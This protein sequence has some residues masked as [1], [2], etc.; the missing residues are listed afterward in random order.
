MALDAAAVDWLLEFLADE[1]AEVAGRAQDL[2]RSLPEG[3]LTD[4][5]CDRVLKNPGQTA[6]TLVRAATGNA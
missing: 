5:L 6:E 3:E 4:V 2:L 1:D